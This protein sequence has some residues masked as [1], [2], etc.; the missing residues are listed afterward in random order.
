MSSTGSNSQHSKLS[1]SFVPSSATKSHIPPGTIPL[2]PKR[3]PY[4]STLV[5]KCIRY[6]INSEGSTAVLQKRVQEFEAKNDPPR[7][8]RKRKWWTL[9]DQDQP[10]PIQPIVL[11]EVK[12]ENTTLQKTVPPSPSTSKIKTT[13]VSTRTPI[14]NPT[15]L[16]L[17][18]PQFE[19]PTNEALPEPGNYADFNPL[20]SFP[21]FP[22]DLPHSGNSLVPSSFDNPNTSSTMNSDLN[23]S[24]FQFF[25]PSSTT[26]PTADV[27]PSLDSTS[28]PT[29][30]S[31]F[32][33][34][35]LASFLTSSSDEAPFLFLDGL[36]SNDSNLNTSVRDDGPFAS[37]VRH[38][39]AWDFNPILPKGL[40]M[41]G[42]LSKLDLSGSSPKVG[43]E[44]LTC[45]SA[46][47]SH[48]S[49]LTTE[50]AGQDRPL[51]TT[52]TP[53]RKISRS[54]SSLSNNVPRSQSKRICSQSNQTDDESPPSRSSESSSLHTPERLSISPS[55]PHK[56]PRTMSGGSGVYSP[57]K[58]SQSTFNQLLSQQ[59]SVTED[60]DGFLLSP[61]V[62]E[63]ELGRTC[64]Q[65]LSPASVA[66]FG[67]VGNGEMEV[68]TEVQPV[69]PT[70]RYGRFLSASEKRA[71]HILS[72]QKRRDAIK[73]GYSELST[74]LSQAQLPHTWDFTQPI[75]SGSLAIDRSFKHPR[76]ESKSSVL[77][78]AAGLCRWY[79]QGNKWL[80]DEVV[81][82]ETILESRAERER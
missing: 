54:S 44:D 4:K 80:E 52:T 32:E 18:D 58:P 66:A 46:V 5:D 65:A 57:D 61:L 55:Q 69:E 76:A 79:E 75:P 43:S 82:V 9:P 21:T 40:P 29:L 35:A 23:T 33:T 71:N 15:E 22:F 41:L 39:G 30:F 70:G 24:F 25:H 28:Q 56:R 1:T 26:S 73:D 63:H 13:A 31:A 6:N 81:R 16:P 14:A 48:H 36:P 78:R 42:D 10:I 11:Q 64:D 60:K 53:S 7:L 8:R 68:D 51:W 17:F 62:V 34:S 19:M 77:E 37:L 49:S 38:R 50:P 20:L 3:P 27:L 67:P 12:S 45:Q 72:E 74:L 59:T 47:G 2:K